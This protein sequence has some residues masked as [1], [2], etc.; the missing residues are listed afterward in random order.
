MQRRNRIGKNL[1]DNRNN[2]EA[3]TRSLL[4]PIPKPSRPV[5]R[6][7]VTASFFWWKDSLRL[8]QGSSCKS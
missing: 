2:L 1:K 7:S 8:L 4:Q 5:D 3:V 6:A